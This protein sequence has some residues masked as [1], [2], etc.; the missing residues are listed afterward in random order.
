MVVCQLPRIPNPVQ[1]T[2]NVAI[3]VTVPGGGTTGMFFVQSP[4]STASSCPWEQTE[5]AL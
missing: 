2:L 4:V 1:Q 3:A 5:V